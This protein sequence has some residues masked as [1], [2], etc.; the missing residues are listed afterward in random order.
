[1]KTQK[2]K[3][4]PRS[5]FDL[6]HEIVNNKGRQITDGKRL[7]QLIDMSL[8][9]FPR[10]YLL[11]NPDKDPEGKGPMT[12]SSFRNGLSKIFKPRTPSQNIIRKAYINFIYN[13]PL[14]SSLP[15]PALKTIGELMRH[16]FVTAMK[17]YRSTNEPREEEEDIQDIL[18]DEG[19]LSEPKI[20]RTINIP[21]LVEKKRKSMALIAKN[22]REKNKEKVIESRKT[23]YQKHRLEV[24][25]LKI[26]NNLN[27]Q[28]QT[29]VQKR[30]I[31][32]YDLKQNPI[33]GV[34]S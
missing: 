23:Y 28:A 31:A 18:P 13:G 34:W 9:D 5:I 8:E 25:K 17:N 1:M 14:F 16:D 20:V 24:L 10:T 12:A 2:L 3:R 6:T 33:T 26:I 15:F 32:K 11:C 19:P 27:S 7:C 29:Q 4:I 22:Y 21:V 30:T